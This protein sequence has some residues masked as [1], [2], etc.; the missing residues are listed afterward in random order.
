M[1]CWNSKAGIMEYWNDGF[2]PIF[3]YSNIPNE[4]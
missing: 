2:N 4:K 1:G 3:H